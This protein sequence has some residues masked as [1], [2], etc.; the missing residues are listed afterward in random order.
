[1]SVLGVP[2]LPELHPADH[3]PVYIDF[4][5][6]T[7]HYFDDYWNRNPNN[8]VSTS[9]F[10]VAG[11]I[12]L[13]ADSSNGSPIYVL[14]LA[15]FYERWRGDIPKTNHLYPYI[16]V[17]EIK[18]DKYGAVAKNGSDKIRVFFHDLKHPCKPPSSSV[19]EEFDDFMFSMFH[20]GL[21]AP[22]YSFCD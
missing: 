3:Y 9:G 13:L 2:V 18:R 10:E 6:L 11:T 5:Y 8:C 1:M 16:P 7:S 19:K 4:G 15:K 17:D 14:A 20:F 12:P 21:P 22:E